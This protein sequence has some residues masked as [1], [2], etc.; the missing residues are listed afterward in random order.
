[1]DQSILRAIQQEIRRI[2][3]KLDNPRT[4]LAEIKAE[5]AAIECAIKDLDMHEIVCKLK[6]LDEQLEDV[7]EATDDV[8]DKLDNPHFG[9]EE[10]KHE[11]EAIERAVACLNLTPVLGLLNQIKQE[12]HEIE[13][14]LDSPEFGLKEIKDEVRAIEDA[15]QD[16]KHG[17]PE[18]LEEVKE[19]EDLLENPEFGLEEIKREVAAIECRLD[20]LNTQQLLSLLAALKGIA[21][22]IQQ[23]LDS[24]EFGL[25]EIKGEVRGIEETLCDP[26][27]GLREIKEE[28]E[29]LECLLRKLDLEGTLCLLGAVEAEL[30]ELDCKLEHIC[31]PVEGLEREIEEIKCLLADPQ[32]GLREIKCEIEQ[33]LSGSGS[34][35]L[36]VVLAQLEQILSRLDN[37]EYGLQ[38]IKS[39]VAS[40]EQTLGDP[41]HGL[42]EIKNEVASIEQT[43]GD[44]G[45]GLQ[46]IKAEIEEILA[47]MGGGGGNPPLTSGTVVKANGA[48]SVVVVVTNN[49][50]AAQN[51]TVNVFARLPTQAALPPSPVL[52]NV[53]AVTASAIVIDLPTT[54]TAFEVRVNPGIP[55]SLMLFAAA[56]T[57]NANSPLAAS[58]LLPENTI[59]NAEFR[60]FTTGS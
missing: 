38:E 40:I 59:R 27:F 51:V 4:G 45:Y 18:I 54:V 30:S 47:G 46:E 8:L 25:E 37:P 11:I 7:L 13:C 5:V 56:R 19:I 42:Q 22:C 43:L 35:D 15:I 34:C 53:P 14:K 16:Q 12:V 21:L 48:N 20:N 55:N 52:L 33:I 31:F 44:P 9:L 10:I 26:H 28:I 39:E 3:C 32:F 23:K 58:N 57:Q 24:P 41:D 1:M 50:A 2:E 17:L 60:P 36:S 49:N 29:D 6:A